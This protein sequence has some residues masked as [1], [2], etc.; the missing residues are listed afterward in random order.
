MNKLTKEKPIRII[1]ALVEASSLRATARLTNA[2]SKKVENHACAVPLH[3]M[4]YNSC[5][6]HK[7][8][9]VRPAMEPGLTDHVWTIEEMLDAVESN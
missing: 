4:H 3:Y 7:T 9:R 6:I 1:S 2:F 8:T 5:R